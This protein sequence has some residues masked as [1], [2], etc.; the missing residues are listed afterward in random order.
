MFH[1]SKLALSREEAQTGLCVWMKRKSLTLSS[2]R[3]KVKHFV[4]RIT[5]EAMCVIKCLFALF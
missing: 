4:W 3:T 1:Y 5:H 2:L